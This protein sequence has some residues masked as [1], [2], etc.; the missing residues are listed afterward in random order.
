VSGYVEWGGPP[1]IGPLDGTVVPC[2]AA[3]SLV[4]LPEDCLSVLRAMRLKWGSRAW[5]RYGFADAFH[6]A[7][8]WYDED[9]IGID[10][11]I[12]VLMAEN[13]RTGMVWDTFMRNAECTQAM[14]LAGFSP[15]CASRQA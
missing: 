6:P 4:F 13:L 7:A 12:S 1:A 8:N 10:Q 3:G 14:Q 2:A 11:G 15:E 5:G 9:V